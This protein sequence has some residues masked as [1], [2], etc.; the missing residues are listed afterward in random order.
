[1]QQQSR[2][3]QNTK[4]DGRW[5]WNWSHREGLYLAW[6]SPERGRG[7][8]WR[9][10]ETAKCIILAY[11]RHPSIARSGWINCRI[12]RTLI[13]QCTGRNR[14][15]RESKTH[16]CIWRITWHRKTSAAVK[17]AIARRDRQRRVRD[18]SVQRQL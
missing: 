1:M 13:R 12:I 5:L 2:R 16:G 11:G 15:R 6:T 8:T 10:T 17:R 18:D 14:P 7:Y 9:R 4:C 3:T